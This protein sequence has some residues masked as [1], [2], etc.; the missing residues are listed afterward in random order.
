M[1]RPLTPDVTEQKGSAKKFVG[2]VGSE[3]GS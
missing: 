3:F 1:L 2:I